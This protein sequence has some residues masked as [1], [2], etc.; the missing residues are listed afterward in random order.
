[1]RK[2]Y[3]GITLFDVGSSRE[4]V[5]DTLL[6]W[7]GG[8][9]RNTVEK[10]IDQII[11]NGSGTILDCLTK[12]E[13]ESYVSKLTN[14][15][16]KVEIY[17]MSEEEIADAI[18]CGDIVVENSNGDF[19]NSDYENQNPMEKYQSKMELLWHYL[20]FCIGGWVVATIGFCVMP[21]NDFFGFL[22]VIGGII[23]VDIPSFK[24]LR[25]GYGLASL[26]AASGAVYEITYKSGRKELDYSEKNM[27]YILAIFTYLITCIVGVFVILFRIF[28]TFGEVMAIKK[29]HN[30]QLSF[31]E[32][33]FLKPIIALS[34]FVVGCIAIS[35][36]NSIA[37]YR[38]EHPSDMSKD[39]IT[40]VMTNAVNKMK[41]SDWS[42]FERHYD[43]EKNEYIYTVALQHAD[44]DSYLIK[45]GEIGEEVFDIEEGYYLYFENAWSKVIDLENNQYEPT[46]YSDKLNMF[47]I[48]NLVDFEDMKKN[49]DDV[50]G[51][52]NDYDNSTSIYYHRK[53]K[54][55]GTL[56]VRITS[57]SMISYVN[58]VDGLEYGLEIYDDMNFGGNLK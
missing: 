33:P 6:S 24:L 22:L 49:L 26:F 17:E 32:G 51:R 57:E 50:Y 56:Q 55:G 36:S 3:Y 34:V 37:N 18:K 11:E 27:G 42:F 21:F 35:I 58:G 1:M 39:E 14:I 45:I 8:E 16:A 47:L 31:K 20:L 43:S 29:E 54:D 7:Y 46:S 5:V 9:S 4:K 15:G 52:N 30:L 48:E 53:S 28:K 10:I 25:A 44:D 19:E 13:A 23:I 41:T 38:L 12:E 2:I 40:T